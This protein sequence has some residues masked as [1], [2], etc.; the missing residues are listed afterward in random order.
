MNKI[1]TI[2]HRSPELEKLAGKHIVVAGTSTEQGGVGQF[3]RYMQAFWKNG[4]ANSSMTVL[5]V[6]GSGHIIWSPFL[7]AIATLRILGLKA[8]GKADLLHMHITVR[9]SVARKWFLTRVAKLVNLPVILHVHAADFPQ[10]FSVLSPALKQQTCWVFQNAEHV[11]V[12]GEGFRGYFID[13]VGVASDRITVL[14]NGVPSQDKVAV[15]EKPSPFHLL[16]LGNLIDRKGV[17]ELLK[18]LAT[19]KLSEI[20][21]RATLAGGGEIERFKAEA[22]SLGID[23]RLEFAGWVARE[24]LQDLIRSADTMVLPSHDEGLPL[25]ILESLALGIPVVA[26]PVGS[27]AEVLTHDE[28]VVLVSPGSVDEL[29]ESLYRVMTDSTLRTKLSENGHSVINNRLSLDAVA[30]Q[31]S[32]IYAD[33]LPD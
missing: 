14:Y 28:S 3:I 24:D 4:R 15:R 19:P 12:L 9:G 31:M 33:C 26:T 16:F 27:I 2:V 25:A 17:P 5:D 13:E 10:F 11:I 32:Q 6:R 20:D 23:E 8:M 7:L 29:A 18:A 1:D 21:W 22:K 30:D